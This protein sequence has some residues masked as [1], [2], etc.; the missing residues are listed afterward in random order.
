MFPTGSHFYLQSN[1][2]HNPEAIDGI[3]KGVALQ[4]K[5]MFLSEQDYLERLK[6]YMSYLVA[7]GHSPKK[8]K[9]TSENVG[10]LTRAEARVKKQE[11]VN[12]NSIIFP[13]VCNPRGPNVNTII[14]RHE[15]LLQNNTIL[16]ELF[17]ANLFI[18]ANKR[19]DKLREL[20][21]RAN[22]FNIKTDLLDQTDHGYKK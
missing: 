6:E 21:E 8:V 20:L 3:Q 14:R 5:R 19:A 15:H 11:T 9:R 4:I 18:V 17:P 12:K 10:K 16:K 1:S 13:T 7:E 2:C 22:R